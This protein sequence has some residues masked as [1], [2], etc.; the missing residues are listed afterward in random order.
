MDTLIANKYTNAITSLGKKNVNELF[1]DLENLNFAY[2]NNKKF[3]GIIDSSNLHH[4]KKRD[5]VLSCLPKENK[6]S[7]NLIKLLALKN[8]LGLIPSLYKQLN[9][10]LQKDKNI[11]YGEIKSDIKLSKKNITDYEKVFNNKMGIKLTLNVISKDFDGIKIEVAELGISLML[12]KSAVKAKIIN[13][14]LKGIGV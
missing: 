12:S 4:V 13:H 5:F 7:A 6:K 3:K 2:N 1:K 14:I 8:K 11:Y 10:K 9:L